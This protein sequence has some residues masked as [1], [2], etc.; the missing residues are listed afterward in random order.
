MLQVIALDADDT[1][2]HNENLYTD[3]TKKLQNLLAGY[4]PAQSVAQQLYETEMRNLELFG[5]GIKSFCLSMIETAV[6]VSSGAIRANA[7]LNV[8]DAAKEMLAADVKLLDGVVE[9]LHDSVRAVPP[10]ADHQG[11]P[12]GPA[13]QAG[14]IRPCRAFRRRR[15]RL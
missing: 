5:Y 3:A 12:P 10:H 1:L 6:V 9:T 15:D 14:P 8:I 2:W 7:I 13:G 11:R 4:A